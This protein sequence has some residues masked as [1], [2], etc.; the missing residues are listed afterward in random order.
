MSPRFRMIALF[1][2]SG[3]G[4]L[5]G[6]SAAQ[7]AN[8]AS[9]AI[10]APRV[11][12][13]SGT[14]YGIATIEIPLRRPV[15]GQGP[16]PLRLKQPARQRYFPVSENVQVRASELPSERPLPRFGEGRLLGRVSNLIREVAN[17]DEVQQET[18]ARRITFLFSG[19][20]PF[21]VEVVD[22][23]GAVGS[24]EVRPQPNSPR[25][26]QILL[27]WWAGFANHSRQ[28]IES[29][30]T[31]PWLPTYLVGM[32][33]GRLGLP[34]PDWYGNTDSEVEQD[35]LLMTL[36]WI[37]GAAR[38]SNRVFA[39][40][41]AGRDL[42]APDLPAAADVAALPLPAP[43]SWQETPS[44]SHLAPNLSEVETEAMASHVPPECFYIRYGNFKNF[45][46]FQDLTDEYGGDLSQMISLSGLS[47]DGTARL[48][49]QLGLQTTVMGRMLG[50]SIIADQAVIGR[51]LYLNDGAAMGV[52]F[53]AANAY[54]LRSSFN[55]DRKKLAN[56]SETL[57]L[58][59]V[60]MPNGRGTLLR[61]SD[62][63][64]RS[65]M[66]EQN[67]FICVTNSKAI[68]ERFL[69]VGKTGDSLA[70]T[71]AFRTARSL[72][73]LSID[74]TIF[75]YFSP[76]MLQGLLTPQYLIELRRRMQSEADIALVYL[77]RLAAADQA[78]PGYEPVREI[79]PLIDAGFLP[80][81][82][83]ERA[84]GSGVFA[85]GDRVLDTRRG[86]RGTFLPIP[87]NPI[88][89][90]TASEAEWYN[91][92]AAAYAQQFGSLDPIF[93]SVKREA[94]VAAGAGQAAQGDSAERRERLTVHAEVAPWQP[95][96]YGSWAQ[97]LGPPTTASIRF[98]ADDI[99]AVQ[100][101]VASDV[102]GPPTHLFVGIKDSH[103]AQPE[104]FDGILGSYQA[105]QTLPGYLGAWPLPGMLD[106]LPLG[107][108][109]GQTVGPN[110]TRLLGGV[111]RFTGGEFSILSFDPA[112]LT[113]AISQLAA[114]ETDDS[115]QVRAHVGNLH[116]SQLEG[117]V[118]EFLYRRASTSSAAAADFLASLSSQLDVAPEEAME[119]TRV[120]LGSDLRCALGG[121]FY[122]APADPNAPAAAPHW[123]STAWGTGNDRPP[124][125][126]PADYQTPVLKWFRG[127]DGTLTQY[128]NRVVADLVVEIARTNSKTGL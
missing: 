68:A 65:Y 63:T 86:A 119:Q 62:N 87:D 80:L 16:P 116:G 128:S 70:K 92:I 107:I 32:L 72:H 44:A 5:P 45:L 117:W 26:Q 54:L 88:E 6:P 67:G 48:T 20:Q 71:K 15:L 101:H 73:P 33:S 34:L 47:N 4:F 98:A 127:A 113:A 105:L 17:G 56:G 36:D 79:D 19:D 114:E 30:D 13:V 60:T 25:R 21:S 89:T 61:S 75:V 23:D 125:Y 66:V 57:S 77:A 31:P 35:P 27:A 106:R 64:V 124:T 76:E 74:D 123:R 118:N 39:S 84:D 90:V 37:S 81:G 99:V 122:L 28:Q 69:E 121:E 102:L 53:Q 97:R 85:A 108:G 51:D 43:I 96:N 24:Y 12:A 100:A 104:E 82:F 3:M 58:T 22:R 10:Q 52:V 40:A 46:W 115:A 111:Y 14:P 59:N 126:P 2:A 1:L 38:V 93:V 120:I 83:G 42:D 109:R 9:P 110:M 94:E 11:T 41:A 55:S 112:L 49:K 103:P 91:E 18:V 7:Y 50:P 95:E 78:T 29:L 8:P